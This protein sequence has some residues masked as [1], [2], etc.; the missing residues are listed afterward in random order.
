MCLLGWTDE[1]EGKLVVT[2]ADLITKL[3]RFDFS[4]CVFIMMIAASVGML[5]FRGQILV[6][7]SVVQLGLS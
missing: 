3:M 5:E 4:Q 7:T 1:Y 6:W 2:A